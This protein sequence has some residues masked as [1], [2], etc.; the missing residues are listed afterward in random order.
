MKNLTFAD[1]TSREQNVS[2]RYFIPISGTPK[3]LWNEQ[4]GATQNKFFFL[5][6]LSRVH[7][8]EESI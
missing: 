7:N 1:H 4:L 6:V 2:T 8:R 3:I 5:R